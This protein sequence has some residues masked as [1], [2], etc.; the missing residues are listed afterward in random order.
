MRALSLKAGLN[1][2]AVSDI[3]RFNGI[4]PKRSTLLA[5]EQAT[6]LPLINLPTKVAKT[7]ADLISKLHSVDPDDPAHNKSHRLARRLS[8]L[9][10]IANWVAETRVVSRAE[11]VAFF[12]KNHPARFG[13]SPFSYSTYKSEIISVIDQNACR[14]RKRGIA[15]IHGPYKEVHSAI[16]ESDFPLHQ[17]NSSGSFFVFLFDQGIRPSCIM[18]FGKPHMACARAV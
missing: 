6:G 3:L 10:R 1:P 17:K 14:N 11:V 18:P 8:W 2:K 5:L 4:S 12:E 13:L 7:Y 9:V 16:N 15:D